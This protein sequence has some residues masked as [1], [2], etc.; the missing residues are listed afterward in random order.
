MK[1]K[2]KNMFNY[3]SVLYFTFQNFFPQSLFI[4]PYQASNQG[5]ASKNQDES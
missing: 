1:A 2:I 4:S 5:I 3:S